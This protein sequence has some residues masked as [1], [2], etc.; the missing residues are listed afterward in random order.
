M[1]RLQPDDEPAEIALPAWARTGE[2]YLMTA[3]DVRHSAAPAQPAAALAIRPGQVMWTDKQRA[4]LAVLGIKDASNADRAVFMH[5]CQRTGLDP[6]SRQIY[7]IGRSE[8][9]PDGTW[10]K[11]WTIQTGI[12]GFRVNR[13]RAERLAAPHD[14]RVRGRHLVRPRRGR[15]QG[16]GAAG[17]ARGRPRSP[18]P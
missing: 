4:A 12:D 13:A 9:Q 15:V 10:R 11:K 1:G 16:L 5:Y 8:K 2:D 14:R 7:M 3:L 6:F 17:A 18:T